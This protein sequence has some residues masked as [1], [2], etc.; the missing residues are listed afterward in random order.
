MSLTAVQPPLIQDQLREVQD[1]Q[2][3]VQKHRPSMDRLSSLADSADPAGT[4]APSS[5]NKALQERYE[6][7]K[8]LGE[9]RQ[10]LLSDYLPSVQQYE[11]SRGA[12]LDLLCGWEEKAGHLPP[13]QATPTNIQAQLQDIKVWM[14]SDRNCRYCRIVG[15]VEL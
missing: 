8:A 2:A 12:W 15:I 10:A 1:F 4:A 6:R 7:L 5:T 3:R 9:E 13:P 11:S 14:L